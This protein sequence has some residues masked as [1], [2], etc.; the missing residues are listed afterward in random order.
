M[1][2]NKPSG[3]SCMGAGAAL[4]IM[5]LAGL[6]SLFPSCFHLASTY[7]VF[8]S[9]LKDSPFLIRCISFSTFHMAK[10]SFLP[11]RCVCV[12][13]SSLIDKDR[14]YKIGRSLN[15]MEDPTHLSLFLLAGMQP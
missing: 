9:L 2:R 1:L 7:P 11:V 15:W 14:L 6:F 10:L 13:K 12:T 8:Y 5:L 4:W 3:S